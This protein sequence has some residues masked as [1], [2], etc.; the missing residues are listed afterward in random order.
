MALLEAIRFLRS[1]F[2]SRLKAA[3]IPVKRG[4][5]SKIKDV[6]T[7]VILDERGRE[8]SSYILSVGLLWMPE[9][10]VIPGAQSRFRSQ[11]LAPK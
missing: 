10:C 2:P 4:C 1:K 7:K 9:I 3:K 8:D 5:T 6:P 11:P